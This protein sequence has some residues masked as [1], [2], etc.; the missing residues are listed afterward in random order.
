MAKRMGAMTIF[1]R[2]GKRLNAFLNWFSEF[3]GIE[4]QRRRSSESRRW[5][6]V[7]RDQ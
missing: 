2:F 7:E 4:I 5:V 3:K 1:I 6:F